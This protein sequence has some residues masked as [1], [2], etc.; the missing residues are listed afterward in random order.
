MGT[1]KQLQL[2]FDGMHRYTI[3]NREDDLKLLGTEHALVA[4]IH[5]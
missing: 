5:L 2:S 3:A 4:C 1:G